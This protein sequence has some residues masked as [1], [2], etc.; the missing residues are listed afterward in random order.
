MSAGIVLFAFL[1]SVRVFLALWLDIRHQ[2]IVDTLV[3]MV[4]L[5]E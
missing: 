5:L 2:N 4:V 3:V 1:P